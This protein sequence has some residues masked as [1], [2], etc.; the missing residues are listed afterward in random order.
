MCCIW[1]EWRVGCPFIQETKRGQPLGSFDKLWEKNKEGEKQQSKLKHTEAWGQ[2]T[3]TTRKKKDNTNLRMLTTTSFAFCKGKAL[4]K[5]TIAPSKAE[6][7]PLQAMPLLSFWE[8]VAKDN[9]IRKL[10]LSVPPHP[11]ALLGMP[12]RTSCVRPLSSL[13]LEGVCLPYP[14]VTFGL[15]RTVYRKE[16]LEIC[17]KETDEVQAFVFSHE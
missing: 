6:L 4:D 2:A 13:V 10:H 7:I 15:R 14:S 5:S 9:Q 12:S 11:T 17:L 1:T 16:I 3:H 8:K